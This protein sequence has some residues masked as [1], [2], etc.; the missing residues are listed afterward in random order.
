MGKAMKSL[1]EGGAVVYDTVLIGDWFRLEF[2]GI[3]A[4]IAG[5]FFSD[6]LPGRELAR[7]AQ[8]MERNIAHA[9]RLFEDAFFMSSPPASWRMA[10]GYWVK[11]ELY[12]GLMNRLEIARHQQVWRRLGL[13]DR[14]RLA[15]E[16]IFESIIWCAMIR[17]AAWRGGII[18]PE[19]PFWFEVREGERLFIPVESVP[20]VLT[21]GPARITDE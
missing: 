20:T 5:L 8:E 13:E 2:R 16:I 7:A 10:Y 15:S 3:S 4:R 1:P 6:R 11:K 17:G 18:P 21:F 14:V 9:E 12:L 19:T